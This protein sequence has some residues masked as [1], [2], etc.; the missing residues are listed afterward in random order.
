MWVIRAQW[1]LGRQIRLLRQRGGGLSR[2]TDSQGRSPGAKTV[3]GGKGGA[4]PAGKPRQV[5]GAPKQGVAC[6]A[7]GAES[8][9]RVQGQGRETRVLEGL[10]D[11]KVLR[12][13][14]EALACVKTMRSQ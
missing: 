9:Q 5:G 6:T 3:A 10:K 1:W 2:A 14:P 13:T 12:I 7:A 8:R 4:E 11:E